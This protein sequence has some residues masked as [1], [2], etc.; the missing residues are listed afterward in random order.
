M[1]RKMGSKNVAKKQV[2]Q[3][4]ANNDAVTVVAIGR[5]NLRSQK[6]VHATD[7]PVNQSQQEGASD[8]SVNELFCGWFR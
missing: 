2:P 7:N 4:T 8:K 5:T 6:R 1:G 3:S